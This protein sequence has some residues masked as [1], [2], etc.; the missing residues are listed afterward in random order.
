MNTL[1]GLFNYWVVV[2]LMMLSLYAVITQPNLIKKLVGLGVLQAAVFIFYI[3]M[4]KVA[5]GTPPI[6][7]GGADV[8][9]SNPLPH[10]LILTAIVV[11]VATMAVGLGLVVR[12]REAYHSIEDDEI[13]EI[14][15]R[16]DEDGQ[17]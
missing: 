17:A 2:V 8:A 9:Y 4:A 5:D 7:T 15:Q 10:A 14:E 3:S 11:G 16:D 13:S 12:I 6:A 1:G